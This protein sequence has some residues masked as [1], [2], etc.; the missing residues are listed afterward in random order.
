MKNNTLL[1]LLF[2]FAFTQIVNS[3]FFDATLELS[4]GQVLHGGAKPTFRSFIFR[5]GENGEE[6]AYPPEQVRQ[7]IIHDKRYPIDTM[8]Y[9]FERRKAGKEPWLL[10]IFIDGYVSLYARISKAQPGYDFYYLLKKQGDE[11]VTEVCF[12]GSAGDFI[13]PEL[14]SLVDEDLKYFFGDYPDLLVDGKL[15]D[16]FRKK[17]LAEFINEYNKLKTRIKL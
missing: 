13:F 4:N 5:E 14:K 11:V 17:D 8:Y 7:L 6:I 10:T 3:Q 1:L 16:K 12:V 2:F 15:N 9:R